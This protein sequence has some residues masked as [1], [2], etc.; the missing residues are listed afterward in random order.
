MIDP[1]LG[2]DVI[3]IAV[4]G[5]LDERPCEKFLAE[6]QV[7]DATLDLA[8]LRI[9]SDLSGAA[10]KPSTLNLTEIPQGDSDTVRVLDRVLAFGYPD[11]GDE[12]LTVTA[13]AISGFL[14][15]EGVTARRSWFKT[16]TTISFGN[17]GGAAVDE[18]GFLVGIPTQGNFDEGGASAHLRPLSLALP[19]ASGGT[20][21]QSGCRSRDHRSAEIAPWAILAG[22]C[23]QPNVADCPDHAARYP[24]ARRY[25]TECVIGA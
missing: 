3:L 25:A 20:T 19:L 14:S 24:C 9:V 13:G 12:T 5:A 15:Q 8:V 16:D 21:L 10:V 7:A 1:A 17:S 4:T 2:Y 23:G 22:S 18:D 6:V 11:I